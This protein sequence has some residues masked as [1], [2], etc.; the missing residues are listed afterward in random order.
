MKMQKGE[1]RGRQPP[2]WMCPCNEKGEFVQKILMT[3]EQGATD[4][5]WMKIPSSEVKEGTFKEE[6]LKFQFRWEKI[7]YFK[8]ILW[9]WNLF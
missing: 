5:S 7:F 4:L 2:P 1:G 9:C 8:K 3:R 6:R